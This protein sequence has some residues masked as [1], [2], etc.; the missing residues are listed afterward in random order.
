MNSGIEPQLTVSGIY[1]EVSRLVRAALPSLSAYVIMIAIAGVLADQ[2]DSSGFD[3][4][5][6]ILSLGLGFWITISMLQ[7]GG[8]APNGLSGGFGTYFGLSLLSGFGIAIGFFL[9]IVPGV[10]LL[11]RW[12]PIYGYGLVEED[13]ISSAFGRSWDQ[14]SGHSWA[15]LAALITPLALY[16]ICAGLFYSSVNEMGE[17]V[18][19]PSILAN[20]L[21]AVAGAM[22]GV[23]GLAVYSLTRSNTSEITEVFE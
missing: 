3:L 5:V 11:V 6:S 2:R 1:A 7:Q 19:L 12:A 10:L 15:I 21:I 20:I 23:I 4:L 22:L 9:L 14:T 18:L 16:L 17:V 13:G 8:L